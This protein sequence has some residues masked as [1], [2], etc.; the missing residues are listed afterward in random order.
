MFYNAVF[1]CE[2]IRIIMFVRKYLKLIKFIY[3]T[4]YNLVCIS[5]NTHP[6]H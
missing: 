3:I 4:L 1:S 6:I 5:L 2:I